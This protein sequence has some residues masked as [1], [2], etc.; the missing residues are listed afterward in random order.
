MSNSGNS[1]DTGGNTMFTPSFT[2]GP[3]AL[4]YKTKADYQNLVP[5]VLSD[6][7]TSIVSYPHPSDIRAMGV[8]QAKPAILNSGYL[9]DNKGIQKNVAFLNITYEEYAKLDTAPSLENMYDM[10]VDK[11]PLTELCDC[12]NKQALS[13]PRSQ[14]NHLIDEGTLRDKCRV[15]K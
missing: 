15:I 3:P 13:D 8:K 5:V 11:D 14:L 6:D 10:I 1:T 7:K 12:G 4:V 9:L 2:P